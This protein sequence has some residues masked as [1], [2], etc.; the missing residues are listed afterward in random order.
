MPSLTACPRHLAPP[1]D[2]LPPSIHVV[3]ATPL[4]VFALNGQTGGATGYWPSIIAVDNLAG[5]T[6]SCAARINN[7][8]V[9]PEGTTLFP[10]GA[11][12]VVCIAT[13]AA[14]NASPPLVFD[15]VVT[16]AGGYSSVNGGPCTG[17]PRAGAAC[18]GCAH[19]LQ[20]APC[21]WVQICAG[22]RLTKPGGLA[23]SAPP[24]PPQPTPT[25][26]S[27]AACATRT[28]T[29]CPAP[30]RAGLALPAAA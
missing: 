11:T 4:Y 13:D 2:T 3:G 22:R 26:V 9:S 15:V 14:G 12:A 27:L 1:A 5:P 24:P 6:V 21:R 30:A 18:E 29:A 8:D 17:E 20:G 19:F 25:A 16:C 28:P 23:A 7:V 10:L